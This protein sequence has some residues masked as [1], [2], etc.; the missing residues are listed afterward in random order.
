MQAPKQ[1]TATEYH[2]I[3]VS[4]PVIDLLNSRQHNR[5][6]LFAHTCQTFYTEVQGRGQVVLWPFLM[7]HNHDSQ[8]SAA[9]FADVDF[10]ATALV[11]EELGSGTVV[12]SQHDSSTWIGTWTGKGSATVNSVVIRLD[13]PPKWLGPISIDNPVV[14]LDQQ[15]SEA[16]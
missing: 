8:G 7:N 12:L 2:L 13:M 1:H 10:N 4:N 11:D 3:T 14:S 16:K 15:Q 6:F 5:P 9:L